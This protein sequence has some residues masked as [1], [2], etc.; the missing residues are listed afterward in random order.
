MTIYTFKAIAAALLSLKA[1][2]WYEHI[3]GSGY[4]SVKLFAK[5]NWVAS[6]G[7]TLLE[8]LIIN[9]SNNTLD[10]FIL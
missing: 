3:Y 8:I 7:T 2:H 5:L 6:T 9:T 4:F 1:L 10:I